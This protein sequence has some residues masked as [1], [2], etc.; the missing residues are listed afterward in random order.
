LA[1]KL[2]RIEETADRAENPQNWQ[3]RNSARSLREATIRLNRRASED[4]TK[5]V[6]RVTTNVSKTVSSI[7]ADAG[8]PHSDDI[9]KVGREVR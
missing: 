8:T 7:A 3:I 4:P 6:V 9:R 5:K 1:L 2:N